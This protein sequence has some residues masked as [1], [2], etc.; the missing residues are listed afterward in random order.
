MLMLFLVVL[1]AYSCQKEMDDSL[2]N[3]TQQSIDESDIAPGLLIIK[4]AQEP[5][6]ISII[7]TRSGETHVQTGFHSIDEICANIGASNMKRV[8]RPSGKFEPRARKAGLHLWYVVEFP[9]EMPLTRVASDFINNEYISIAEPVYMVR[10]SDDDL[11][12]TQSPISAI[13]TRNSGMPFNDPRLGSQWHYNNLGNPGMAYIA[14]ADIN[15]FE[16]WNETVG[17]Q[18]VIVAITDTGIDYNHPDLAGNMWINQDEIP[19]NGIDD[20]KN[21]YIDD[22]YGYDFLNDVGQITPGNHGTHVAGTIGAINNNGIGVSGIAGG[23]YANGKKGVRLMSCQTMTPH[24][25]SIIWSHLLAASFQYAAD[26]GAVISQNSWSA[27]STELVNAAIDYFIENAGTDENG[28]QIG[29]MKGGLVIAAAGNNNNQ[30]LQY[31]AH[32]S[33]VLAVA[34][35]GGGFRKAFD[36]NYGSWIDI[37]APGASVL[38]TVMGGGYGYMSGTSMACPHVSGIAALV[39]SK[40]GVG[41]PGLTPEAVK[42]SLSSSCEDTIL[43]QYNPS[44]VDLL[45]KGLINAGKAV[46]IMPAEP[47]SFGVLF[48]NGDAISHTYNYVLWKGDVN[49]RNEYTEKMN[50]YITLQEGEAHLTNLDLADKRSKLIE[51]L[52]G[53]YTFYVNIDGLREKTI[54]FSQNVPLKVT[55]G[56]CANSPDHFQLNYDNGNELIYEWEW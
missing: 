46:N 32:Y 21:G 51:L 28:R 49:S 31:P 23:N 7:E 30:Q 29:P 22:Y 50:S 52:P 43:H 39:V 13:E 18:D 36:S 9:E 1:S 34:S 48:Y 56:M 26:N 6:E 41:Q 15:L 45:G 38:S 10:P 4:L 16:A 8:F 11:F 24:G 40:Y 33:G 54:T 2:D 44:Y 55:T 37:T 42:F 25:M 14:G 19:G 27:A 17:H 35:I 12:I 20:D 5:V 3:P 47:F 53:T